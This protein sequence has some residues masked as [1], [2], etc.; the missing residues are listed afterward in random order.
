MLDP[1]QTAPQA[2]LLDIVGNARAVRSGE[3][4]PS[5]LAVRALDERT[6]EVELEHPAGYFPLILGTTG[7]LPAYRPAVEQW[8][9]RWTEAGKCVS[10]GPFRLVS[11]IH[12]SGYTLT[13]NPYY[14]NRAL[15]MVDDYTVT[16]APEEDP[17]LP[18]FR[19]QV[20]FAPVPFTQLAEVTSQ[21]A[22]LEQLERSILPEVWLLVIQPD[23]PPL[24]QLELRAAL[25]RAIDRQRL[26]DLVY[27]AVEPASALVPPA[28]PGFVADE[29]LA[30]LHRFAPLE[31]YLRW[32]PVRNQRSGPLRLTAPETNDPVEEAVVLDVAEQL[33]MNLGV[34]VTL[35][36]ASPSDWKR[37]VDEGTFQLLWWRWPLP[38]PDGA[39][40]YE[41]LLSRDRK[42]L[43]GLHWQHEELERFLTLARA[44]TETTRRLGAYRQ[45]ETLVQEAYVAVPVV[46]PVATYL[47]Q[48]WVASLPR[49]RNGMLVGPGL[50]FNRFVS[51][52]VLD[53][54]RRAIPSP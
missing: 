52:V 44:E 6:L 12:G 11:W 33:R 38:F 23:T 48:P 4:K 29:Q 42:K 10:N 37:T 28:V 15:S 21:E 41:W 7:F 13:R 20:D 40:V 35:E 36:R 24:D 1:A 2:W 8:G 16:I 39:A 26:R 51:G 45:C 14:W 30:T 25:S 19:G 5:A 49:A 34:D 18:F 27:G 22:L 17:L 31:A 9:D 3:A 32:E 53:A 47:V 46:Y 50:L 43:R 54:Q